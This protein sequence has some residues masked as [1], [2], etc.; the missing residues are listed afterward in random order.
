LRRRGSSGKAQLA[1]TGRQIER[2][3]PHSILRDIEGVGDARARRLIEAGIDS[4][5][6]LAAT[7]VEGVADLLA[8][9][10]SV[11]MAAKFIEDAARRLWR[12]PLTR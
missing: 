6:K 7:P 3:A 5:A 10:V 9:G 1:I 8:P 4:P 2:Q 11:E 12:V